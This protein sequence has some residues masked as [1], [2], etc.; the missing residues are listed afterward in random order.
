MKG[1]STHLQLS[2][3]HDPVKTTRLREGP[4]I[5]SAECMGTNPRGVADHTG[6]VSPPANGDT[7]SGE[8]FSEELLCQLFSEPS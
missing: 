5:D 6:T 2:E 7:Q 8:L 4:I 1:S 3:S